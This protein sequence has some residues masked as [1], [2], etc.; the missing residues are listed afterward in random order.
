MWKVGMQ[1][2]TK[3]SLPKALT[4]G[5]ANRF[6]PQLLLHLSILGWEKRFLLNKIG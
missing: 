4:T 1:A 5:Y 3:L 6:M 2:T